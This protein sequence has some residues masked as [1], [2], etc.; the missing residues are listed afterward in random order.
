[1][2]FFDITKTASS[3]HN[4]GLTRVGRRL[5]AELRAAGGGADASASDVVPVAWKKGGWRDAATGRGVTPSTADWIFTAELFSEAE[6]EGF[7]AFVEARPRA[8]RMAAVFHDAIPLKF[9]EI[10]WAKSVQRAPGYMKLLAGFDRVLAVSEHSARELADFW[11]WQGVA[12]RATIGR[13]ANGADFSGKPRVAEESGT[14]CQPVILQH[15]NQCACSLRVREWP[16]NIP[17][18]RAGSPCH[19]KPTGWQPV[20]RPR[21]ASRPALACVGILEPRKNQSFLLDVCAALWD[22]GAEFDLHLV[23]RVNPEFGVPLKDKVKRL[24]KKYRGLYFH[25][26][27]S[28]AELQAVYAQSRAAVFPTLAEGCGLPPLEAMWQGV[29]C[30][31]SDLPVLREY[32]DGG[33]CVSVPV[34]DFAAWQTALRNVLA[35]D[36]LIARL[37]VEAMTRPLPTWAEAA[38]TLRRELELFTPHVSSE[39]HNE[40]N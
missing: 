29:P 1:M 36:A 31:C 4:S 2:I 10:T 3:A 9:P 38:A 20:P 23:G 5:L 30:V 27:A 14:G 24:R 26:A 15:A 13:I 25:E 39:K 37:R 19:D 21:Q 34:N 16:D 22:E 18:P 12:P 11:K 6:R 28:D 7:R 35:D 8:C 17:N 32:T 33:G 40:G